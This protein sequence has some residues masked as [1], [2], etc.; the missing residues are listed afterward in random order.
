MGRRIMI[1]L[2]LFFITSSLSGRLAHTSIASE[3][4]AGSSDPLDPARLRSAVWDLRIT[5]RG[6][7]R[8]LVDGL[9]NTIHEENT[10]RHLFGLLIAGGLLLG[11]A[12]AAKAQNNLNSFGTYPAGI[13]TGSPY[14]ANWNGYYGLNRGGYPLN[15]YTYG[16]AYAAPGAMTYGYVPGRITY[17]YAPGYNPTYPTYSYDTVPAYGYN[18]ARGGMGLFRGR[19]WRSQ[20]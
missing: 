4:S 20:P 7:N 13:M 3:S 8:R 9:D 18:T 5:T 16:S 10:M 19:M 2:P 14:G 15:T 11:P 1:L 12:I 6:V 17:G